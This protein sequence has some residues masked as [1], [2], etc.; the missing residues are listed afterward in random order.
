MS[1]ETV[2]QP[3][4]AAPVAPQA[5]PV[6]TVVQPITQNSGS[7]TLKPSAIEKDGP[8]NETKEQRMKRLNLSEVPYHTY[9]TEQKAIA[10]AKALPVNK[11]YVFKANGY[12]V[13]DKDAV[14]PEGADA[15]KEYVVTADGFLHTF[16]DK[17]SAEIYVT[18]HSPFIKS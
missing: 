13:T 16:A 6:P 2:V 9:E 12:T 14:V 11:P 5:T 15:K 3:V 8:T 18:T 10:A 7:V 1:D 17:R 4:Q